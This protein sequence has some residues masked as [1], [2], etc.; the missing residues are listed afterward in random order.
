MGENAS[1]GKG[2]AE[3]SRDEKLD[4]YIWDMDETLILLKSLLTGTYA[5]G[6]NGVKNVQEGVEI[7]KN[8][9]KQILSLCDDHFF[10]EQ[11][12]CFAYAWTWVVYVYLFYALDGNLDFEILVW[13]VQIEN[14]NKPYLDVLSRYDDGRNLSEYDFSKDEFGA[15]YDDDNKRKLAYR[16]RVIAQRYKQVSKRVPFH[17]LLKNFYSRFCPAIT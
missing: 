10:Y 8:W 11:V 15:S 13:L 3:S 14:H 5:E 9:E 2:F 1:T 4:V 16:H 7:G 17:H 12:S 6:F